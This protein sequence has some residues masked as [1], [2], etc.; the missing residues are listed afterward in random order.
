MKHCPIHETSYAAVA[1]TLF[2]YEPGHCAICWRILN[3]VAV[4]Q[5]MQKEARVKLKCVHKGRMTRKVKPDG[6]TA[7]T[8]CQ[9][10]TAYRCT[11]FQDECTL[12]PHASGLRNCHSCESYTTGG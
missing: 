12:T 3:P 4:A 11:Y 5:K 7:D 9:C 6:T 10:R 8:G 1:G 2:G